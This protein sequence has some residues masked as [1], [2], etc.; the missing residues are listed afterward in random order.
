M[1]FMM[2]MSE[3]PAEWLARQSQ[4]SDIRAESPAHTEISAMLERHGLDIFFWTFES[5]SSSSSARANENG[6]HETCPALTLFFRWEEDL[7]AQK[8]EQHSGNWNDDWPLT[9]AVR[10]NLNQILVRHG[11]NDKHVSPRTFIFLSWSWEAVVLDCLARTKKDEICRRIT[12]I[13]PTS[14][15]GLFRRSNLNPKYVFWQSS[16]QYYVVF[17]NAAALAKA[18]PYKEK[19]EQAAAEILSSADSERYCSDHNVAM[20]L[21]HMQMKELNLWGLAR[22]D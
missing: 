17:E 16:R 12:D 11:Y 10:A 1:S 4:E 18:L 19:L 5:A 22:E 14:K 20:R 8:V 6:G 7:L 21:T 15:I 2:M 9:S 3:T 13:L